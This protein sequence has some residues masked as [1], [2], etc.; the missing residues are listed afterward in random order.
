MKFQDLLKKKIG[1]VSLGCDK[2]R[3]DLEKIINHFASAGFQI[4]NSSTD[5]DIIIVNTCSFILDAR[6]ESINTIIEMAQLK[7]VGLEKLIVTGCLNNMNYKD[8][9]S[10]LPEVDA[11]V[12]IEDNNKLISIV[13][14]LYNVSIPNKSLECKNTRKILTT[15]NHYAYLKIAD[16]CNNFCTY[17]TIPYIRGRFKS[18]TMESLLQEA[19]QLVDGGVRE[20]IL[21]AQDVTKYGADIYGKPALVELI[22]KLSK[23]KNLDWIRLLYCYPDLISDELIDEMGN[24]PKVCKYIDVPLQHVSDNV[25]KKMNR[26]T[27]NKQICEIIEKLRAKMPNMSIRTTFILGFPGETEDD[28]EILCNFVKKYKLDNVGFFKYSREEGTVADKL[29]NHIPQKIKNERLKKLSNIQYQIVSEKNNA[30]I[31]N[32][33]TVVADYIENGYAVCHGEHLCPSVDSVIFVPADNIVL[34]NYYK[35]KYTK[36]HKYDMKGEILWIYLIKLQ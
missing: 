31:G 16:G 30:L 8:L 26:R 21:V 29:P 23:I 7:Y 6:K 13:A 1:F 34:G 12:K 18:E 17:C 10:S 2:N 5:A 35:I 24:N 15:P 4:A 25:L 20:I 36:V 14:E 11:F 3:V 27:S 19:Q 32:E 22:R 9:E 28:F 33:T